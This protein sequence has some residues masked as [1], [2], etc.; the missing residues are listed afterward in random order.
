MGIRVVPEYISQVKQAQKYR[1]PSQQ[2]LADEIPL[3]LSTVHSFLNGKPVHFLNFIEICGKL[4]LDWK[5][6]AGKTYRTAD[7][8]EIDALVQQVRRHCHDKI[9]QLYSKMK[10]L[11]IS[12]PIDVDSLYVDVNILEQIANERWLDI[13]DLL[14]GFKPAADDFDRL[15]LGK[16]REERVSGLEAVQRYKRLMVLGKPGSGKTTFLQ[17]LAT[18]CSKGKLQ[19]D[20]VPIFIGL[21]TFAKYG[22][23]EKNFSLF[24]YISREFHSCGISEKN[25]AE[26]VLKYGKGLILLDGLD[27]V[28]DEDEY[29]VVE[30]IRQFSETYYNNRLIVTCRIAASKYRLA[31]FTDVEVADF[32]KAQ[33]ASFADKWFVAVTESD[34]E[35][36]LVQAKQFV[37]QLNL[38]QN[39][40]IRELAVTPLWLHMACLVFNVRGEFPSN[41][42]N[43]YQQ[44]LKIMLVRWDE[45]RGIKRDEVYR[46]L[47]VPRKK[48]LLSQLAAIAFEQGDYF[49]EQDKIQQWIADYLRTL[50]DAKTDPE[51]LQLDSEAVLKAIEAQHG[52]LVER[53]RGIYSFSHLTFQEYFTARKIVTALSEQKSL[54]PLQNLVRHITEKRWREVFLLAIGMLPSADHLLQLMKQQIDRLVAAD[55]KLQQFLK[56]VNQKSLSVETS[57]SPVAFRALYFALDRALD[58]ALDRTLDPRLDLALDPL[59]DLTLD[60][61]LKHALDPILYLA[62]NRALI[63]SLFR[64]L[65]PELVRAF[66]RALDPE[67][68]QALE[69][70]KQELPNCEGNEDILDQCW[71]ANPQVSTQKLREIMISQRHIGYD[72]QFS[73]QQREVLRQYYDA[74]KLL[75]DC[76]NSDCKVT[77]GVRQ[78]IEDTLLLPITE[79]EKHLVL[80]IS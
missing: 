1:F 35:K 29:E 65:D 8:P 22:R 34:R 79:I 43:L 54:D 13:S 69:T 31:G 33:I 60:D 39:Q 14:R 12:Q 40:Q 32:D 17:Y 64:A 63:R 30:E 11:D 2:A 51:Q 4:G 67:L 46:N 20:R 25:A 10:L 71:Q 3:A 62:L 44:G 16:V 52:L 24:D 73:K 42:A 50:P 26:R 61:A 66:V 75:M 45:A 78:Q 38:P 59:L 37:E 56:W 9:E 36:G 27:E 23:D 48:Q 76:L 57:H 18:Q 47:S 49:L 80:N 5:V 77:P 41:R 19:S 72:W 7:L 21:K 74:N 58:D 70:L 28:P 68:R 53:A 15:G 55:E 6:I